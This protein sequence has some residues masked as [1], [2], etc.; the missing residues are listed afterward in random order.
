[1]SMTDPLPHQGDDPDQPHISW[2][3]KELVIALRRVATARTQVAQ[4]EQQLEAQAG[5]ANLDPADSIDSAFVDFARRE[6]S[7][8]EAAYQ[9]ILELPDEDRDPAEVSDEGEETEVRGVPDYPPPIDL[10]HPEAS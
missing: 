9:D 7:S 1:M 5:V 4:L 2:K 10:T 6:L 3:D 8:A